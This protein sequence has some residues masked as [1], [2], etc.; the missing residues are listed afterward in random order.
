MHRV[1]PTGQ[2][3]H[4]RPRAGRGR[5]GYTLIEM[6]V[7]IGIIVLVVAVTMPAIGPMLSSNQQMQAVNMVN[8]ML[9]TAQTLALARGT[10]VAIR[11]ERA[12]KT[13]ERG[14]MVDVN[15]YT[16]LT[17]PGGGHLE[18]VWLDHQRVRI[19]DFAG[20]ADVAFRQDPESKVYTL[21][22][23]AWVAPAYAMNPNTTE[24][25]ALDLSDTN[26]RYDPGLTPDVAAPFNRLDSFFIVF[27]EQGELTHFPASN[28][29][30]A[31]R[32]QMSMSGTK[33]WPAYVPS[34]DD[35]AR[36][37]IVYDR[38]VYESIAPN[39]G[40][41]RLNFLRDKART[42]YINRVTGEIV[43]EAQ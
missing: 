6:M 17:K 18:P 33:V 15:G 1:Q 9:T 25:D 40:Q 37:L 24:F 23:S 26:L 4:L 42:V 29:Y 7:V 38:Q 21:P 3:F 2:R 13:N 43:E 12:F 10:P 32:T 22:K 20:Y 28:N 35:S 11:F 19:L 27:N 34:P 30:Y 39:D 16:T 36:G 31:D 41:A 8:G 5:S 14:M